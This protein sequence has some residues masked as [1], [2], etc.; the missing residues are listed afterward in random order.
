MRLFLAMRE[1]AHLMRH[2][3]KKINNVFL[4]TM[5]I[6]VFQKNF[7]GDLGCGFFL[8]GPIE[9][10]LRKYTFHKNR[11]FLSPP[12]QK[13]PKNGQ[14]WPKKNVGPKISV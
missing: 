14:K 10:T 1:Y 9:T 4:P 13:R 2:S 3:S 12:G 5:R 8:L 7:W 11:F 6:R